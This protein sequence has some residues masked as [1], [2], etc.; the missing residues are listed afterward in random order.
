MEVSDAKSPGRRVLTH[1]R[2]PQAGMTPLI[3]VAGRGDMVAVQAL[4]EVGAKIAATDDVRTRRG[5]EGGSC[6][7][8]WGC[9]SCFMSR[10]RGA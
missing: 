7:E 2:A 4:L 10:A 3:I 1:A 8:K 9:V 6:R 5:G